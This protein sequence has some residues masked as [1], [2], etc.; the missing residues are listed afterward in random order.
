MVSVIFSKLSFALILSMT[1]KTIYFCLSNTFYQILNRE[2]IIPILLLEIFTDQIYQYL[3]KSFWIVKRNVNKYVTHTCFAH[4]EI[5]PI[6]YFYWK[7]LYM[8]RFI[9]IR[10]FNDTWKWITQTIFL[11][12]VG[13]HRLFTYIENRFWS[14]T[15]FDDVCTQPFTFGF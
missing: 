3:T 15:G 6:Y 5:I 12:F 1:P 13:I 10:S 9:G 7:Q 14:V 11:S 8:K 2:L 4:T